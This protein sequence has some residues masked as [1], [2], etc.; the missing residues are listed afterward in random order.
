[1]TRAKDRLFLTGAEIRRS[2]GTINYKEASRFIS[3]LPSQLC[4]FKN[5]NSLYDSWDTPKSSSFDKFISGSE[6]SSKSIQNEIS[7]SRFRVH[8]RVKHPSFGI[9]VITTI[10][11]KGDN[12]KL[13]IQ[14]LNGFTKTFLERY[15]PLEPIS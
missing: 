13:T 12:V 8:Q 5:Y 7:D 15:T 14:F 1:M 2:W 6:N 9:G 11:G 3:E 10:Q 4:E